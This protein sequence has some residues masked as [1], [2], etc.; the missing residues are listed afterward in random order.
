MTM[1]DYTSD[2]VAFFRDL[3]PL[4]EGKPIIPP[5]LEQWLYTAFPLP[6]GNPAARNILDSRSKKQGKSATGGLVALYMAARRRNAEVV[7][8]A[9]T[10]DQ[11]RDRVFKSAKYAAEHHPAWGGARV[12]R[13]AIELD[14]GSIIQ[15]ISSDW[16]GAAG[17]NYDAV[18]FD[19][20]WTS[21]QENERR[22]FDELV[23]PPSIENGCRWIAS[24]A[25]FL[26]ESI[27][28]KEI[29]DKGLAGVH[30]SEE[31]PIF[32]H[33]EASLL[34][35]IDQGEASWRMPWST[36][37]FMAQTQANERPNTFR[38]L[39][40]NEWTSNESEFVPLEMWS[41]CYA[42]DLRP[43]QPGDTRYMTLGVDASTSRDHTGAV[44]CVW[45]RELKTVDVVYVRSWKPLKSSLRD[46]KPTVDLS[47]LRDEIIRLKKTGR[48]RA[49]YFDPYQLHQLSLDMR[50]A[51]VNMRELPQT[52]ARTESGQ[53]LYYAIASKTIR[54]F[55]HPDLNE[56]IANAVAAESG[57]GYRLAK[58]RTSRKID[59][60]VALSMAHFKAWNSIPLRAF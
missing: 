46:G 31:L 36:P 22:R 7:I 11:A 2:I 57:R 44:G 37:A 39:W 19:E 15:A 27:L 26:G 21:T 12:Y 52:T 48:L 10:Q 23:I 49:V 32:H 13:D 38:R 6:E 59:L 18:I 5:F 24:Y 55:N 33:Q 41:S 56:H 17:G 14:N 4:P 9:S 3:Y 1:P 25:G 34:A 58:E 28:L 35:F 53:A 42:P 45:N 54:H 40:L 47:G 60:A 8:S 43:F 29:W 20:L 50:K 51:G 30:V 16:K